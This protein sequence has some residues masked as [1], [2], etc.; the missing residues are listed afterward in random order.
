MSIIND[1]LK[2][3]AEEKKESRNLGSHIQLQHQKKRGMNWGPI[4]VILVLLLI[5]GPIIA[6]LFSTPIKKDYPGHLAGAPQ[7]NVPSNNQLAMATIPLNTRQAQFG[8]EEAARP[9]MA[10]RMPGFALSGIVYSTKESYCLINNQV[11]KVGDVVRGA[12]ILAISQN[13]VTISY[14]GQKLSIPVTS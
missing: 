3:A 12:K 6:P 8:M 13:E 1:A 4:F 14:Q 10:S 9:M 11:A 5:T 7:S 2:K